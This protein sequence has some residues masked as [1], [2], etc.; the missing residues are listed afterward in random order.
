MRLLRGA[1]EWILA[2]PLMA[3]VVACDGTSPAATTITLESATAC[4]QNW[5]A[6]TA[7]QP[8][9]PASPILYQAGTLYLA[10]VH[11]GVG[12]LAAFPTDGSPPTLLAALD[13]GEL[14]ID[15]D[16]LLFPQGNLGNQIYSIPLTGGTPQL[17]L[18]GGAGRTNPGPAPAHAFNATDFYWTETSTT[19][20]TGET[21]VWWQSRAGGAPSQLGTIAFTGS[22][23]GGH[24]IAL[25]G[26][27]ALVGASGGLAAAV[28]FDGSGSFPLALPSTSAELAQEAD[29]AAMDPLGAY[30]SVRGPGNQP[31]S[32][33]LAPGDGS[34]A[35]AVWYPM[36]FTSSALIVT[37]DP[38]G[39]WIVA[40]TQAFDDDLDHIVVTAL[41]ARGSATHLAC[42]P[43]DSNSSWFNWPVAL[44]PDAI[45]A[46]TM[47]IS[48][49]TWEIDRI[50]R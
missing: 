37:P 33:I 25:N 8:G 40:G 42:S 44:A 36:P 11:D 4:G 30:W 29:L 38:Q 12:S 35:R 41:D 32:V 45:Y 43:G 20:E 13:P 10:T 9:V 31:S 49:G 2:L 7:P 15:G 6:L 27:A 47:N 18:D 19:V 28:P 17:V 22:F 39:G 5:R 34:P 24:A 48:A 16:Q 14:W 26:S 46:A 23:I 1:T 3:M 50:A 21:S